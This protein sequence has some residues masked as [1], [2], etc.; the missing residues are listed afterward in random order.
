MAQTRDEP[1][2]ENRFLLALPDSCLKRLKPHLEFI[3][4]KPRDVL[5]RTAAAAETLFFFNRGFASLVKT[6]RDGRMVEIGAVGPTSVVGLLS[7]L[8][9]ERAV[10]ETV[11][12][13][14]GTGF[15]IARNAMLEEMERGHALADLVKKRAGLFLGE[16]A[17]TAACNRLHSL[18]QRC[19]RW[20][21]MAHDSAGAETFALT[22]EFLELMLGVQRSGLSIV[23]GA[24]QRSGLIRYTRGRV[25]IVDRNGLEKEA[26]ECYAT[27][28]G[29]VV[30]LLGKS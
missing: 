9:V 24:L 25:T 27:V 14:S 23:A 13:G 2:I 8:G 4:V 15:R 7:L 30:H 3:E 11:V 18:E 5:I 20:L 12:Q 22:H 10:W 19:C 29:Q 21:L 26:C 6:M 16:L 28:R 17:Q 1:E